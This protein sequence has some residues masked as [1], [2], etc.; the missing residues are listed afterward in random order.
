MLE[1][2]ISIKYMLAGYAVIL[3][4]LAVYVISLVIRWRSLEQVLHSL[5]G[6]KKKD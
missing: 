5:E 1:Y 4:V 3:V 6:R 2:A